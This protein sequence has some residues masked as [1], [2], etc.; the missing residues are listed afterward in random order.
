MNYPDT[1]DSKIAIIGMTGRFPGASNLA[2]FWQNLRDG[3]ESIVFFSE[4]E[5]E[6]AGIP[7]DQIKN[8]HYIRAGGALQDI[9]KFD[10]AF[11]GYSPREAEIMDP[12]HRFFLECCWEAL[13][14]AGYDPERYTHKRIGLYAGGD[15]SSYLLFNLFSHRGLIESLGALQATVGNDKD[16]LPTRVS[17][18][19]NLKGPSVNVNTACSTSLVAVH[20]ACQSLLNG[21]CDMALAGGASI[22]VPQEL[23]YLYREGEIGSPDGHC[24]A[25]DA[26]AQG[27]TFGN[28]VGVVVL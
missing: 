4:Q 1:Y 22:G 26:R 19:L 13:E 24:R 7:G 17:Y 10:A 20:L 25:F 28:G 8:P 9:E 2:T 23:G 11:F 16:Y 5:M 21:E 27:T 3:V 18:K 14:A 12:Q 15:I 6:A